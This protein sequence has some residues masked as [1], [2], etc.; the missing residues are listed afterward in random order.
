MQKK[1]FLKLL[2]LVLLLLL[3]LLMLLYNHKFNYNDALCDAIFKFKAYIEILLY[4][5]LNYNNK[6]KKNSRKK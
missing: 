2:K 3:L 6:R 4:E 1:I 5:G